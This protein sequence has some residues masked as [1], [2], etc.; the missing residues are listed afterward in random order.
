MATRNGWPFFLEGAL[1]V[2]P[3]AVGGLETLLDQ[4]AVWLNV[5]IPI[6]ELGNLALLFAHHDGDLRFPH[7]RKLAFESPGAVRSRPHW[8]SATASRLT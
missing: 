7:P 4:P 2:H 5:E 1:H 6:A 3:L 8:E